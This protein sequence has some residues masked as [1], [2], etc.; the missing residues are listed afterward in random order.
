LAWVDRNGKI[1]PLAAPPRPYEWPRLSPDGQQVALEIREAKVDVWV[2][3]IA[4]ST[5]TRLTSETGSSQRPI[6]T[7]D[8]MRV[9]YRATRA[10]TRNIFWKMANGSGAEERLTTGEGNES[11]GSWLLG[12]KVLAYDV[13]STTTATSIWVLGMEGDRKAQPFLR[14]PFNESAPQFSPDGRSLAYLSN[15]SGRNGL[16]VQSYPGPGG[17]WEIS[18]DG[19][20]EPVWNRNGRELFYRSGNKIWVWT[21][22][23]SLL[24]LSGSPICSLRDPTCLRR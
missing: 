5:S 24:S 15:E 18:T 9:T 16:Y 13:Q 17:K 6:W 19:G 14:T 7:P 12:G 8:G 20:S 3:N 22:P 4:R 2:Y 11:P 23:R 10:G 1:E 21:L